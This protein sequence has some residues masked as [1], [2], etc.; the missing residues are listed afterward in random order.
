VSLGAKDQ[1]FSGAE[2]EVYESNGWF[3]SKD[4]QKAQIIEVIQVAVH[5]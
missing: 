2:R 4:V 1:R 3:F 5:V